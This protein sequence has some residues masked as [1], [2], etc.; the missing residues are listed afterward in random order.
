[1]EKLTQYGR[2]KREHELF[3]K[4]E[5]FMAF[6]EEMLNYTFPDNTKTNGRHTIEFEK[7]RKHLITSL[8]TRDSLDFIF[9]RHDKKKPK[10]LP[11]APIPESAPVS[12][13]EP[14]PAIIF[15]PSDFIQK[16]QAVQDAFIDNEY[17]EAE[18][19][20]LENLN[21]PREERFMKKF[22]FRMMDFNDEI[23]SRL[24]REVQMDSLIEMFKHWSDGQ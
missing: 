21:I 18:D 11:P 13:P 15:T 7:F 6:Y 16:N 2:V 19:Y 17:V 10:V 9:G 23:K 8:H 1:M 5:E 24:P 22:P 4:S 12:I 3:E 20:R 14:S